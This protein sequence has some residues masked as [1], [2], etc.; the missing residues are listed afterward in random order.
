MNNQTSESSKKRMRVA[1]VGVR[2]ADQVTLKGY[3]RVLLR[4]DVELAWVS[5][6]E[7]DIDLFMINDEFRSAASVT[8]LL[9]LH[10]GAPVLF[11]KRNDKNNEGDIKHNLLTLPLKHINSLNDWLIRHV[12]ILKDGAA[13]TH[14]GGANNPTRSANVTENPTPQSSDAQEN[15]HARPDPQV[16]IDLIQLIQKRPEQTVAL[17]EKEQI[18]AIVDLKRQRVWT[19]KNIEDFDAL[20]FR[21]HNGQVPKAEDAEDASLWLWKQ[22]WEHG[23][24]LSRLIDN[25]AYRLRCWIKPDANSRRDLLRVMTAI[26][27]QALSAVEIAGRVGISVA[28]AKRALASLLISGNLQS[29]AY[30]HLDAKKHTQAPAQTAEKPAARSESQTSIPR[31]APAPESAPEKQEKIGFLARLR[32]KLGL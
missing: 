22:A 13:K 17:I 26:E 9:Q 1:L 30:Q 29:G 5:A 32:K 21:T 15:L 12:G 10:Q 14:N 20:R 6:N 24:S 19:Q 2:P 25:S 16:L 31:A 27:S 11:V 8:K 3:L 18:I 23:D 4:L 28:L 7:N